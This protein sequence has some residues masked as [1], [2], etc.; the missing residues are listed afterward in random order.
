MKPVF[1]K[2]EIVVK[3]PKDEISLGSDKE[4][5][6]IIVYKGKKVDNYEEGDKILYAKGIGKE[7]K[8]FG[9]SLWVIEREDYV[10]CQIV[11]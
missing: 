8:Y 5:E 10:I 3:M 9:E 6:G 11:D 2:S 4:V 7:L 1:K